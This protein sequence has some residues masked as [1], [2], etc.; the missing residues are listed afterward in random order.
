M[1]TWCP[2]ILYGK[3]QARRDDNPDASFCN[4]SVRLSFLH[5]I[6][7]TLLTSSAV[8]VWAVAPSH[9]ALFKVFAK[10]SAEAKCVVNMTSRTMTVMTALS[11]ASVVA[12]RWCRRIR[13]WKRKRRKMGGTMLRS[14]SHRW[15]CIRSRSSDRDQGLETTRKKKKISAETS[16]G[17]VLFI[18]K[19]FS[20]QFPRSKFHW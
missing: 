14:D 10:W 9:S 2:C 19:R 17:R 11:S 12:A 7:H 16:E 18:P 15:W 8:S 5:L 13:R 3:T 6:N 1:A 20:K 4:G